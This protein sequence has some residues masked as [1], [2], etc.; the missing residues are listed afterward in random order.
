MGPGGLH[1]MGQYENCTGGVVGYLDRVILNENHMYR[2]GTAKST[3][4]SLTFDPEGLFG[5][6]CRFII[7]KLIKLLILY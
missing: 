3:Y 1:D 4:K 7:H 6:Y 5:K 2:F